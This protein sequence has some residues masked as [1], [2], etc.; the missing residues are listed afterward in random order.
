MER[1]AAERRVADI[2]ERCRTGLD[3]TALHHEILPRLRRVVPTEAAFLATVDPVTLLFTSARAEEPLGGTTA[4]FLDN[5]FGREDVNKFTALAQAADPVASLDR[6]TGQ[7]RAASPRYREIMAPLGLGDELRAALVSAGRC[8]GVLCLHRQD[9]ASGF[10]E[11]D[12]ALVRALGPHL[13]RALRATAITPPPPDAPSRPSAVGLM[14]FS[15]GRRLVSM[16][17]EAEQWLAEFP[18]TERHGPDRIPVAV[19][20]A[21]AGPV[22][23]TVRL[24]GRSGRWLALHTTRAGEQTGVVIEPARPADLGPILLSARGLTPAQSRVAALVARGRSTREMV[25]ELHICAAT[26]QEHLTAVFDKFGVHS[27]RELV[28]ELLAD[29]AG[30]P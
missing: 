3:A 25:D 2:E 15:R 7:D 1:S 16:S 18:D 8:W 13:A 26:V 21:A 20:A 24:R 30:P 28:A 4:A 11:R 9:T 22:P 12:I 6:A 5:E 19:L 29:L 27:R 10:T 14:L 23:S 17:P